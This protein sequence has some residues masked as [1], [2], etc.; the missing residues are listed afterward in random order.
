MKRK[1]LVVDDEAGILRMFSQT[2]GKK[3]YA[4]DT[5]SGGPEALAA[6]KQ[7][8]YDLV[9]LD[10]KM[11]KMGGDEVMRQMREIDSDVP[12]YFITGFEA[13]FLTELDVLRQEGHSFE[14]IAKPIDIEMIVSV[15]DAILSA[16][17]EPGMDRR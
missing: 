1:I 17:P 4:V 3:G 13:E 6:M 8:T 2:L 16:P 5:A 12:V 15:A 11:P 14:L 9:F 10:L 7:S